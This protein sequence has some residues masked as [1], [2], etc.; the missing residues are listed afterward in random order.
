MSRWPRASG[1]NWPRWRRNCCNPEEKRPGSITFWCLGGT[2]CQ[3]VV[4][5]IESGV[6]SLTNPRVCLV[7]IVD[8][9]VFDGCRSNVMSER[10]MIGRP[11][12]RLVAG[13]AVVCAA[14][15]IAASGASASSE[16][17][18][19]RYGTFHQ[20]LIMEIGGQPCNGKFDVQ[21]RMFDEAFGGNQGS[22]SCLNG[23]R[24]Q[25][26]PMGQCFAN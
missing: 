7:R 5:P 9:S 20:P 18:I 17:F 23:T 4:R 1:A 22:S 3:A 19:Q 16:R 15:F 2:Q 6:V 12:R 13:S 26:A 10:S 21:V 14:M 24:R 11:T 25:D 8:C